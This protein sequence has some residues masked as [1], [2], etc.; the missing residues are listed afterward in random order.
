MQTGKNLIP[1]VV[2][3]E[4]FSAHGVADVDREPERFGFVRPLGNDVYA[5]L[6]Q[7]VDVGTT[8]MLRNVQS[9]HLSELGLS[10][11]AAWAQAY[12]N[13]AALMGNGAFQQ[14]VTKTGTGN[15]WAVWLGEDFTSSCALVPEFYQWCRAQLG[16]DSFMV[17]LASTQLVF[18]LQQCAREALAKFD[19]VV[20]QMLEGSTKQVS[21]EWFVL[22]GG[23]LTP[24]PP[25]GVP[26]KGPD[27]TYSVAIAGIREG[28][29]REQVAASLAAL[30]AGYG[31]AQI[32]QILEKPGVI[33]K[34]GVDRQKAEQYLKALE[35]R[36]CVCTIA[37]EGAQAEPAKTPE[38]DINALD[39]HGATPLIHA[40]AAG[41]AALVQ[42]LIARGASPDA[43]GKDGFTPAM[44]AAELGMVDA[45]KALARARAKLDV[46]N[47]AGF[48]ATIIA[49]EY[50]Q[51]EALKV[52]IA[53]GANLN[54][55]N[56]MG[57]NA[58]M[59]AIQNGHDA[60]ARELIGAGID[61][62]HQSQEGYRALA[63]AAQHGRT[64]TVK[65]LLAAHAD[66]NAP[67]PEGVTAAMLACQGG[68]AD[69]LKLLI[70]AGADLQVEA[71]NGLSAMDIALHYQREELCAILLESQGQ[72]KKGSGLGQAFKT[73]RRILNGI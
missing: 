28:M 68:H 70:A 26:G 45:L 38:G 1:R 34:R 9:E 8:R 3:K 5:F 6:A 57:M 44:Y 21:T 19:P 67:H 7:Q 60:A 69:I 31:Q 29:A 73:F 52:L 50:G 35:Q 58:L 4:Y 55:G 22:S 42:A 30:F 32:M 49:A 65:A 16:G 20:S 53:A 13:I 66:V 54:I 37:A 43:V 56:D 61:V 17:C 10:A 46:R 51:L 12:G 64:D 14:S 40:V 48:T 23:G 72:Q 47:P 41:D 24:L 18:V 25:A 27:T 11:D 15:D 33:V 36:G 2:H 71:K 62:E 63:I 39:Q 59:I